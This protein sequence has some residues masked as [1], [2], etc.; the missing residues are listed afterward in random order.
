MHAGKSSGHGF[1][2]MTG[3]HAADY[4][5]GAL[6]EIGT[7]KRITYVKPSE[8]SRSSAGT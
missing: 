1:L 4:R 3:S 5:D 2:D 8:I 7:E 6:Y